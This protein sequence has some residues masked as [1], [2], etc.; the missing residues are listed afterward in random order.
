[1]KLFRNAQSP[2]NV[3]S[4][5][6]GMIR[7][8]IFLFTLTALSPAGERTFGN[9]TLS[10]FLSIY[11]VDNSG[12][13][14]EEE[15][16]S[17]R[18]DRLDRKQRLRNRWDTDKDGS[19][20]PEEREAAKAAIRRQIE[21]RRLQRFSEVDSNNDRFLTPAEFNRIS[22]VTDANLNAP[23]IASR[24]FENL[25]LNKDGKISTREF[26]LKL[27]TLPV[28][29]VEGAS[30]LAHPKTTRSIAPDQPAR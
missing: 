30:P 26:L 12:G 17:L 3:S 7:T 24:L 16:Q 22:A 13:L 25:D 10:E 5:E 2:G 11:D 19:I 20:S 9:G 8:L 21:A 18:S 27:D 1:M 14:S 29:T 23:G 28:D 4:R 15:L 6:P